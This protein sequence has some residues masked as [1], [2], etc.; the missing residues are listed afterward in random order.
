MKDKYESQ[1]TPNSF[2]GCRQQAGR[3]YYSGSA[4]ASQALN[5]PKINNDYP[6]TY[7][8]SM[9]S[10]TI[11]AT[12]NPS[13]I[14]QSIGS[15]QNII[16]GYF[17]HSMEGT[18][19]QT[20]DF[21][22]GFGMASPIDKNSL[23]ES[24]L[25]NGR[26]FTQST[27]QNS[28]LY[29]KLIYGHE[30]LSSSY[31]MIP[32]NRYPSHVASLSQGQYKLVDLYQEVYEKIHQPIAFTGLITFKQLEGISIGTPPIHNQNI[33]KAPGQYYPFP[34]VVGQDAYGF[35]TGMISNSQD[36][37]FNQIHEKIQDAIYTKDQSKES[38]YSFHSHVLVLKEPC[39]KKEE[40]TPS[41]VSHCLHVL[42]HKT[43]VS[44]V[45]LEI[46]IIQDLINYEG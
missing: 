2:A 27:D 43:I 32:K 25:V 38:L 10:L 9:S 4:L 45:D 14:L 23:G 7:I 29:K 21:D 36:Y 20:Q 40:I 18:F 31:F 34:A 46:Y 15:A 19:Y 42:D 22:C 44:A 3:V 24:I 26:C 12:G 30:F 6:F 5:N 41:I 13:S 8:E 1:N 11:T 35:I 37:N 39:K 33:V 17:P 16:N 28:D